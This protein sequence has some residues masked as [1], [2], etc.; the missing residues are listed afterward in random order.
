VS[1][2]ALPAWKAIFAMIRFRPWLWIAN[3]CAMMVL[4]LS[5]QL[6]ANVLRRSARLTTSSS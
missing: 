6:P 5:F 1:R 2:T 4:M 3:F